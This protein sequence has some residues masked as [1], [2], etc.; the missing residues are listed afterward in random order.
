MINWYVRFRNKTWL[1]MFVSG[2]VSF[3][4]F[5]L[6]AFDVVPSVTQN[7]VMQVVSSVLGLLGLLGIVVDPTT[8]DVVDSSRALSYYDP[9]ANCLQEE[10]IR[11][12]DDVY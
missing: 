8:Q 2:V 11:E 5:V 1:T 10:N 4:Y 3:V 12:E 7:T 9:A 6:G